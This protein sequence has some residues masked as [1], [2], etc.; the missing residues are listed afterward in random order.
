MDRVAVPV[1]FAPV[2][3]GSHVNPYQGTSLTT[4]ELHPFF[5][6]VLYNIDNTPCQKKGRSAKVPPALHPRGVAGKGVSFAR[7][8]DGKR[9]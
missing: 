5:W 1:G 8:H 9:H 7:R 4:L 3:D 2:Y 6:H